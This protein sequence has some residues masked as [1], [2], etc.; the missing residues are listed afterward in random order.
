MCD[1]CVCMCMCVCGV[2]MCVCVCVSMV[3]ECVSVVCVYGVWVWCVVCVCVCM[4]V[5][6]PKISLH[7][8]FIKPL[9]FI[10][11]ASVYFYTFAACAC[12]HAS[13]YVFRCVDKKSLCKF[14]TKLITFTWCI[15]VC[16]CVCVCLWVRAHMPLCV[17]R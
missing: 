4:Y 16:V 6:W 10:L 1:V 12:V 9:I 2:C 14:Y 5:Y 3:F 15:C 7:T 17:Y 13:V 11:C 8:S